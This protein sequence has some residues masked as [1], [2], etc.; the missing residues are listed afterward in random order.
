[1]RFISLDQKPSWF[2]N[3]GHKG[4]LGKKGGPQ[5]AV[6]ENFSQPRERYNIV[7]LVW[8]L[9][10]DDPDKPPPVALLF[11]GAQRGTT[12]KKLQTHPFNNRPWMRV[13]CQDCGSYRSVDVVEALQWMLPQANSA[14]ESCVVLL[15]TKEVADVV[16]RKGHVLL[17]HGGGTTP[18][19]Q[20]NDTHLHAI[21]AGKL[22]EQEIRWAANKRL[23]LIAAREFFPK[24]ST[25]PSQA[26]F[27]ILALVQEAWLKLDHSN[28]AAKG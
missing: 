16:R 19:A 27:D 13:Q 28:V 23:E 20:V 17:F 14:D 22:V 1:M 18:F 11:K 26:R 8:S 9:E 5:P 25:T 4:T 15:E 3:A 6:K 12:W 24:R 7:T 2:N 21:L 10:N